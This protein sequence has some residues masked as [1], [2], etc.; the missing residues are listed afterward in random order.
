M[1]ATLYN[2][3][4]QAVVHA[5]HATHCIFKGT[6]FVHITDDYISRESV[7]NSRLL[8]HVLVNAPFIKSETCSSFS[9]TGVNMLNILNRD[10]S[11]G[12][13]HSKFMINDQKNVWLNHIDSSTNLIPCPIFLLSSVY[14]TDSLKES[15]MQNILSLMEQTSGLTVKAHKCIY[16]CE[17][18]GICL[19][20]HLKAKTQKSF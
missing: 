9:P 5:T 18:M 2:T 20:M 3:S 16:V 17:Y 11:L 15:R 14:I 7:M 19:S 10:I 13:L 12:K 1:F 6:V 4:R 8:T